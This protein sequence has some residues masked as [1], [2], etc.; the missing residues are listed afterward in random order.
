MLRAKKSPDPLQTIPNVGPAIAEDL[1]RLGIRVPADLAGRDPQALYERL[2]ELDGKRPDP[3]V[4]DTFA[5]AVDFA[6][7]K[8]GRPWWEYS[9][10]RLAAQRGRK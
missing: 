10:R 1:R 3:C 6:S 5:A 4:L 7:G 2:G 8:P 9:R